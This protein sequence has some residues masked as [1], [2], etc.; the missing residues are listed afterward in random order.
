MATLATQLICRNPE[1]E[2]ALQKFNTQRNNELRLSTASRSKLSYL[3]DRKSAGLSTK[4]KA[5]KVPVSAGF[6]HQ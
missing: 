3:T 4:I 1:V 5:Q 6:S 2:E